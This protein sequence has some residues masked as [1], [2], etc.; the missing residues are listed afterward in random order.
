MRNEVHGMIG[1]EEQEPE[2][3]PRDCIQI[4]LTWGL[5]SDLSVDKSAAHIVKGGSRAGTGWLPPT[6]PA[7]QGSWFWFVLHL[8]LRIFW[9]M[10]LKDKMCLYLKKSAYLLSVA[11]ASDTCQP[12]QP[13]ICCCEWSPTERN[14]LTEAV[15]IESKKDLKV[16]YYHLHKLQANQVIKE[17][18][19]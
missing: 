14:S 10:C 2:L 18:S 19:T 9:I 12:P 8:Y 5:Q 17:L 16:Q 6:D 13:E 3:T 11:S 1:R 7:E 4:W 15:L